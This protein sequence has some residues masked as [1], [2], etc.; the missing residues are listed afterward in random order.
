MI[1]INLLKNTLIILYIMADGRSLQDVYDELRSNKL[2]I[3]ILESRLY[4]I[5]ESLKKAR[6]MTKK[7]LKEE[8]NFKNV[9]LIKE[10]KI[11]WI[12][13][14]LNEWREYIEKNDIFPVYYMY[15]Y[16]G[17]I[18]QQGYYQGVDTLTERDFTHFE[19][20]LNDYFYYGEPCYVDRGAPYSEDTECQM[21]F[22][23]GDAYIKELI[24]DQ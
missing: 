9:D 21:A 5:K 3:N 24:W 10:G 4:E 16:D 13:C 1:F 20:H 6:D 2:D 18:A 17:A 14:N 22:G 19:T 8:T 15:Y 12:E 7:L 11:K 23:S